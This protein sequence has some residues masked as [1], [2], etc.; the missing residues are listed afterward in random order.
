[1]GA[2]KG[3]AVWVTETGWPVSGPTENQAVASA[4]N[5]QTYW[6]QVACTLLGNINTYWY[7]LQETAS[8]SFS[9]VSSGNIL[10]AALLYDLTCPAGSI[11]SGS[12]VSV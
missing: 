8:P 11:A 2:A 12:S 1:V 3:K 5:A 7:I 6:S 9:V 10:S 4:Q